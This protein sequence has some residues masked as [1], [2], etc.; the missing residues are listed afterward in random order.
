MGAF[1]STQERLAY[2]LAA[3]P[4]GAQIIIILNGYNDLLGSASSGTRP[5][6]PFQ[7]GIRYNHPIVWRATASCF[8]IPKADRGW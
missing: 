6:D 2:Y 5:G 7:L 3:S 8:D 1:I 4:R